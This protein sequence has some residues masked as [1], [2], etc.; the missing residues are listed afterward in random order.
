MKSDAGANLKVVMRKLWADHVIWTR[1]Y[2]VAATSDD[3]SASAAAARLLR[4]Q[5]DIGNAI[6]PYYGN[7]AAMKLTALLKDHINIAVDLVAAA[8]AGDN[9]RLKRCQAAA[10]LTAV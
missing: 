10:T 4:N 2:I 1:Q 8:K 5:E 7:D 6:S 3:P 9:T